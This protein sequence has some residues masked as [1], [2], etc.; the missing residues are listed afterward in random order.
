MGTLAQRI[1]ICICV[2]VGISRDASTES[3]LSESPSTGNAH[4]I[5]VVD[6]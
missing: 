2:A 3:V 1:H 4:C 5:C 6:Y